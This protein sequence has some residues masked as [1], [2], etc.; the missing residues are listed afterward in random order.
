VNEHDLAI[1]NRRVAHE[2]VGNERG[3]YGVAPC[4]GKACARLQRPVG[5]GAQHLLLLATTADVNGLS[6]AEKL[7][8]EDSGRVQ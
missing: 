5:E 3:G 1:R 7:L 2:I 6:S 4:I 8:G